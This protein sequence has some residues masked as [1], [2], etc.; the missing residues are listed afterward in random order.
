MTLSWNFPFQLLVTVGTIP[1]PVWAVFTSWHSFWAAI[2][3]LQLFC[4][5]QLPGISG[6]PA[7][8]FQLRLPASLFSI[9]KPGPIT[10][11]SS[12]VSHSP[13]LLITNI[14]PDLFLCD[15]HPLCLLLSLGLTWFGL[16]VSGKKVGVE[17]YISSPSKSLYML[18]TWSHTGHRLSI[19]L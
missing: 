16:I 11:L 17:E 19:R 10:G 15:P 2:F 5:T 4:K 1:A 9:R 14:L 13:A 12:S 8:Y 18:D 6:H 3:P 7:V